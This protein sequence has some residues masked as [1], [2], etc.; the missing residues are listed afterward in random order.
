[1]EAKKG[2][3]KTRI[4][5][6]SD[7]VTNTTFEITKLSGEKATVEKKLNDWNK[8]RTTAMGN[9][10]AAEALY[11]TIEEEWNNTI[12]DEK[13]ER[14]GKISEQL[15]EAQTR[16]NEFTDQFN[17]P[18]TSEQDKIVMKDE[19]DHWKTELTKW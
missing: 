15:N 2:S 14:R 5:A 19:F 10:T 3:D 16:V 6:A 1:M 18:N 8:A 13:Q 17:D 4:K 12:F 11:K 7:W 9:M